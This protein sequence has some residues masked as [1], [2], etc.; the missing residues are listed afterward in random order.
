MFTRVRNN[1]GPGSTL[2]T[3]MSQNRKR[4]SRNGGS[5][6]PSLSLSPCVH[7]GATVSLTFLVWYPLIAARGE[8]DCENARDFGRRN[9]AARSALISRVVSARKAFTSVARRCICR[10]RARDYVD[11]DRRRAITSRD[12]KYFLSFVERGQPTRT[13]LFPQSARFALD[14]FFFLIHSF[15]ASMGFANPGLGES[16]GQSRTIALFIES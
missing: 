13:Y 8:W 6:S 16:V 7:R 15:I 1:Q 2:V 9:K 12:G 11:N 10:N 5:P 3:R 4:H 14:F